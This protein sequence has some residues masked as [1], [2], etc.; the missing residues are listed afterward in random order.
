MMTLGLL[1]ARA[2]GV[3]HCVGN[4]T[5]D[6]YTFASIVADEFDLDKSYIKMVDSQAL[7]RSTLS[8]L[9]FASLRGRYLGMR[10]DKVKAVL[11]AKYHPRSI[12]EALNHWKECESA[13][14]GKIRLL[15][16][17]GCLAG[18]NG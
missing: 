4:E 16:S 8:R 17:G 10:N 5:M 15:Q 13:D 12:K 1:E 2:T 3:Y 11:P 9:G 7:Y 14:N 6:R 18:N